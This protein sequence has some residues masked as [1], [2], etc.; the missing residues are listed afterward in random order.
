MKVEV[1]LKN[2]DVCKI[3][4][5]VFDE[6]RLREEFAADEN[7]LALVACEMIGKNVVQRW[8]RMSEVAGIMTY[9]EV[10]PEEKDE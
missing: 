2:G 9:R 5:G 6:A 1:T 7:G 10:P 3:I 4:E 8:V